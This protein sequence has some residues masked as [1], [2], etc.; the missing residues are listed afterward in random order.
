MPAR[1]SETGKDMGIPTFL[2][3][4]PDWGLGMKHIMSLSL[5]HRHR[6]AILTPPLLN[7]PMS[8]AALVSGVSSHDSLLLQLYGPGWVVWPVT[9][10][11]GFDSR[12]V[13]LNSRRNGDWGR[14][15]GKEP[16]ILTPPS[17]T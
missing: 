8:P 6:D 4:R 10:K 9:Q 5:C 14:E 11:A 13:T 12:D 16:F 1:T 3:G 7:F 15:E 17:P 2:L